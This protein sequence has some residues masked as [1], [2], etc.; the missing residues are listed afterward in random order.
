MLFHWRT[1]SLCRVSRLRRALTRGTKVTIHE[2]GDDL[3]H[4]GTPPKGKMDLSVAR[5]C[6]GSIE[7]S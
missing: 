5:T 1:Q 7:A 2:L 6:V 3:D 4:Q